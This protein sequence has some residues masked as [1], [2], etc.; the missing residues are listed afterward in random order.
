[1]ALTELTAELAA[2]TDA[3]IDDA[4][5]HADPMLLRGL[6]F[7]L[8]GAADIAATQ[9]NPQHSIDAATIKNDDEA[10]FLRARLATYLKQLRDSAAPPDLGPAER[11]P[12]SLALAAGVDE[13]PPED[14]DVWLEELAL[15]P[16]ARGADLEGP[17]PT[18]L[19]DIEVVVIGA[20]MGGLNAAA[21]LKNAGIRF[22]LL[23]KNSGVGG[24]WYENRYPGARVD[25]PS[26][27]Y[28]H[29]L[30]VDFYPTHPFC[31]REENERYFN[32]LADHYELRE[33]IRHDTEVVALTWDDE[34]ARWE[35]RA[36][37]PDGELV[38]N[39][40]I[41]IT[42]V[43]LLSRPSIPEIAGRQD[44]RG[45]AFHSSWWP[46][47]L[48]ITGKRVGVIGTGCSGV[49]LVPVIAGQAAQVSV[50]QRT[51]QWLFGNP[52]Y[53]KPYPPQVSWLDRNLPLF[54]NF[55][56]FRSN[57][58]LGPYLSEPK[59]LIDPDFEDPHARSA[60]NKRLRDERIAFIEQ[61]LA[62]RPDLIE[63]MI[64]PHPPFSARPVQVD[65]DDCFYDALLRDDVALVTEGIDRITETGIR[66]VD[67]T[68]HALDVIVFA[69]GFRANE[70][71][72]PMEVHGRDGKS[73][74]DLWAKD[75]PRAYLGAMLP[76]FPN[77][78]MVYGPNMNPYGGLGVVNLEEMVMRYTLACIEHLA[79]TGAR[80]IEPSEE[81]YWRWNGELDAREEM[82]IYRDPRAR[83]YY[84][85]EHGRSA[86][87]CPFT[88]IEMWHKL[89]HPDHDDLITR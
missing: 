18:A 40:P 67:G 89:R 10:A 30:G 4:A 77:L 65:R 72:W 39:V 68:E 22:T 45:P 73:V 26:R 35:V 8:T 34:A 13:V 41:V 53:L 5:R 76:D 57:W 20:G 7:Q 62:S 32:W 29:I 16:W 1:M 58:L 74:L 19:D 25:S 69:T 21:Q 56:R 61:K 15:D 48:D 85:N 81:A 80:S 2:A 23:E 36:K 79:A 50:F 66:T 28:L 63:K 43:G 78:F 49:Q 12:R 82:K 55:M 86:T 52:G 33:H 31:P 17:R 27:A 3:E 84:V 6:L 38:L 14:L 11:L 87:N 46:A 24:T 59:R 64:P 42:A 71:L 44:F 60:V 54:S 88:G 51:P 83:S 37:T 47:D 75:G 70:A 9:I